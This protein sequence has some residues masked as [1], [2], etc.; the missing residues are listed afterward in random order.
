MGLPTRQFERAFVKVNFSVVAIVLI[1]LL[2]IYA[3]RLY[4]WGALL[5]LDPR[6]GVMVMFVLVGIAVLCQFHITLTSEPPDWLAQSYKNLI[7]T[8]RL[9]PGGDWQ[10]ALLE[11]CSEGARNLG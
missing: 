8:K 4:V 10:P 3:R 5:I 6:S 2:A 9:L 1:A 7:K 11:A